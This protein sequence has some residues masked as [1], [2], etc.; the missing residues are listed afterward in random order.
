MQVYHLLLVSGNTDNIAKA[1]WQ[2]SLTEGKWIES[3]K[4]F[5]I[6]DYINY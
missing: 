4:V 6:F 2:W 5:K 1:F 3:P